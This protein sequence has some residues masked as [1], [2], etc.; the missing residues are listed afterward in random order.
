MK[1]V[2]V[3]LGNLNQRRPS[4]SK[5]LENL[6]LDVFLNGSKPIQKFNNRIYMN[7]KIDAVI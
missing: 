2:D 6:D 4:I 5:N 1:T 3:N 7:S